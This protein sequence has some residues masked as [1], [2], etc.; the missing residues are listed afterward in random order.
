MVVD[1]TP[2]LDMVRHPGVEIS[3]TRHDHAHGSPRRSV[4]SSSLVFSV[5]HVERDQRRW[6]RTELAK[7]CVSCVIG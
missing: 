3:W 7:T 5:R 1:R 2:V 6:V 4:T